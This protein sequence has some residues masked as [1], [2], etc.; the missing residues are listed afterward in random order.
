MTKAD[1]NNRV[2]VY[3]DGRIH[4]LSP[5]EYWYILPSNMECSLEQA[6]SSSAT[7]NLG[8]LLHNAFVGKGIVLAINDLLRGI[9]ITT[10]KILLASKKRTEAIF[11]KIRLDHYPHQPSRLITAIKLRKNAAP[12]TILIDMFF[13]P[14]LKVI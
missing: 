8:M 12:K 9:S 6:K 2:L 10:D 1:L 3:K 4:S 14:Q 13:L 5:S 7:R 11:E